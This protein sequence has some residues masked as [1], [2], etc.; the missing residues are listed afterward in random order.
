MR[1]RLPEKDALA[2]WYKL[3][4]PSEEPT[5]KKPRISPILNPWTDVRG[6]AMMDTGCN[7][8]VHSHTWIEN[9]GATC[10]TIS[11]GSD[12]RNHSG[13]PARSHRSQELEEATR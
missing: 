11:R 6:W 8:S 3:N 4:N 1:R 12:R 10:C 7:K 9:L 2:A 5:H 13:D